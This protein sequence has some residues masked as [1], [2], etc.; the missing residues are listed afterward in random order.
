MRLTNFHEILQSEQFEDAEF[1]DGNS[2]LWFLAPA[3]VGTYHLSGHSFGRRM[4]NTSILM[5][6]CI[7]RK[8]RVVNLMVTIVFCNFWR[9]SILTPVNVGTCHL[10]GHSFGR[11]KANA[12]ILMKFRTLDKVRVVNSVVAI[13]FCDSRCLSNLKPV[14]IGTCHPLGH[15]Y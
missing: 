8:S 5:K 1:I 13:L 9:L 2:F 11:R 12:S 14:N 10:L 7:L 4:A 3:N 15:S 6:L